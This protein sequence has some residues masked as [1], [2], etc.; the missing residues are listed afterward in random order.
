MKMYLQ[1][2][3]HRLVRGP[4]RGARSAASTPCR[5]ARHA[6][7]APP[8]QAGPHGTPLA[9]A[10]TGAP[11]NCPHYNVHVTIHTFAA[12]RAYMPALGTCTAFSAQI[13]NQAVTELRSTDP[14]LRVLGTTYLTSRV[15]SHCATHRHTRVRT[16][17][18]D[19]PL[20]SQRSVAGNLRE[21]C[22]SMW[23]QACRR[24]QRRHW[25]SPVGVV[26]VVATPSD[27]TIAPW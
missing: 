7:R 17:L 4:A 8:P 10:R 25:I 22:C 6:T 13:D 9:P 1:Q 27:G 16:L 11:S 23:V 26:P 18:V 21:P 24:A 12:G 20:S 5:H 19:E 14:T 3:M 15:S 2:T